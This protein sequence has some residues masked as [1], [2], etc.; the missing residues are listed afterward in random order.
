MSKSETS[1]VVEKILVPILTYVEMKLVEAQV[2]RGVDLIVPMSRDPEGSGPVIWWRAPVNDEVVADAQQQGNAE[3]VVLGYLCEVLFRFKPKGSRG[4]GGERMDNRAKKT[5]KGFWQHLNSPN[6]NLPVLAPYLGSTPDV[7]GQYVKDLLYR[8]RTLADKEGLVPYGGVASLIEGAVRNRLRSCVKPSGNRPL[9]PERLA[10]KLRELA[11]A[12][13]EFAEV[14]LRSCIEAL[15]YLDARDP[16]TAEAALPVPDVPL[17]VRREAADKVGRALVDSL[18]RKGDDGSHPVVLVAGKVGSGRATAMSRAI[19]IGLAAGSFAHTFWY[20]FEGSLRR[21]ICSCVLGRNGNTDEGE[22]FDQAVHALATL[23][24]SG[25][26]LVALVDVEVG[27]LED[28]RESLARVTRT[29][30]VVMMTVS[31]DEETGSLEGVVE[32]AVVGIDATDEKSLVKMGGANAERASRELWTLDAPD[33]KVLARLCEGNAGLMAIVSACAG[34]VGST[35]SVLQALEGSLDPVRGAVRVLRGSLGLGVSAVAALALLP[36]EGAS[37]RTIRMLVGDDVSLLLWLLDV[38]VIMRDTV[39]GRIMLKGALSVGVAR[40]LAEEDLGGHGDPSGGTLGK[41][42]DELWSDVSGVGTWSTLEEAMACYERL[43]ELLEG[44]EGPWVTLCRARL[45]RLYET[46]NRTWLAMREHEGVLERLERAYE[47]GEAMHDAGGDLAGIECPDPEASLAEECLRLG[48]AQ[49]QYARRAEAVKTFDHGIEVLGEGVQTRGR[50]TLRVRLLREKGWCLHEEWKRDGRN[51]GDLESAIQAKREALQVLEGL[52][53]RATGR[54]LQNVLSTLGYSLIE[55]QEAS[56]RAEA[57]EC[58]RKGLRMLYE[59]LTGRDGE[60]AVTRPK[61]AAERI[62][63]RRGQFAEALYFYGRILAGGERPDERRASEQE[64][65]EERME[66]LEKALELECVALEIRERLEPE[67]WNMRRALNLASIGMVEWCLG[68]E[69]EARRDLGE[70]M[71]IQD[72]RTH[73]TDEYGARTG[74]R[75]EPG[76]ITDWFYR[77]F[78]EERVADEAG[79]GDD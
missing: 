68:R 78:P 10:G 61:D 51:P 73:V 25:R 33:A 53:P 54:E 34:R 59:D 12:K 19:S 11:T 1:R 20:R 24:G 38:G 4:V 62:Q 47:D 31:E 67:M 36:P 65:N 22:R 17:L 79:A 49:M 16:R 64:T 40:A 7:R 21:S 72:H 69:D 77:A 44:R 8:S 46:T 29:G 28:G 60:E 18:D 55:S 75:R 3:D 63:A 74:K 66:R 30:A 23:S 15:V 48:H 2:A 26:V 39:S 52:D 27:A 37:A 42:A 70:A 9:V 13:G 50:S 56:E 76:P 43:L 5:V 32:A 6:K 14:S 35:S 57:V 58:A 45:A 41:A 71:R